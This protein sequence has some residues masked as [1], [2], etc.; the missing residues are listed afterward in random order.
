LATP[1]DAAAWADGYV[2]LL[3]AVWMKGLRAA[4]KQTLAGW[5]AAGARVALYRYP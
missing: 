2:L 1:L 4:V 3:W 5:Q